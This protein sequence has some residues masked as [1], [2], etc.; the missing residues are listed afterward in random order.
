V[1]PLA[2]PLPVPEDV[3]PLASTTSS[4]DVAASE[5]IVS[6]PATDDVPTA[7]SSLPQAKS[8][9]TSAV[10]RTIAR[11]VSRSPSTAVATWRGSIEASVSSSIGPVC[12]GCPV[13]GQVPPSDTTLSHINEFLPWP[14]ERIIRIV[15][16]S[17]SSTCSRARF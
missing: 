9:H 13:R 3:V 5:A 12:G 17:A 10:T 16:G 15:I 6:V 4:L 8:G 2:D 1:P 14:A 7:P 11:P